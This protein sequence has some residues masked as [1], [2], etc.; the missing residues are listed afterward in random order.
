MP[1]YVA[2]FADLSPERRRTL[3]DEQQLAS[4][5][6]SNDLIQQIYAELYSLEFLQ[7]AGRF[8]TLLPNHEAVSLR[9][10]TSGWSLEVRDG[11]RD[12]LRAIEADTVI[13]C[14]GFEHRFPAFLEPLR[15]HIRMV[16]DGISVL[17]DFSV[18]T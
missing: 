13:F 4:D 18:E 15:R 16:K 6:I 3:L 11:D 1:P 10:G 7:G 5:V 12:R 14:T 9:R 8:W 2:H 17:P